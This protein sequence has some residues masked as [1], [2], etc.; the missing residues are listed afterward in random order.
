MRKNRI[1]GIKD[2]LGRWC[3]DPREV[4]STI[5]DFYSNLFSSSNTCQP[6]VVLDSIQC[7]VT[8]DMN[9]H[10]LTEFSVDEV[11][12]ALSQ[13]APLK[14]PGPD[15]M[16]PLFYQHY[17]DLVGKDI[18]QSVLAFLNSA[19]LP[20]HLNH[21]FITLIPKVKNPELV[22]EF[23]PI[24]LCNVLYKI[25]SKVLANQLKKILPEIITENQSAFT[26]NHLIMDNILLAFESLHSMQ[27]H[28]SPKGGYMA[29]KL[30]MSKAYDR[31]EW[32]FLEAI[33]RKLGFHERWISLMMLCIST[34]S[35]SILINGAPT[36]FIKPTRGIRQGDPLLPF[37]FL[38]CTEGLHGLLSQAA[39]RGDIHGF[40]LCRRS[41]S[42]THLLFA[43]DSLLFCRSN[44]EECQKV[45]E[46]LQVYEMG[47]GQQLNKAKTTIF[48]SKSTDEASR[49][50]IKEC[51]GVEEI[52]S[53]EK[54]LGLPSLVGRNKK[55]SFNY[56]KER[57]WRKLQGWEEKLLS[58]A[59]REILIKAVA[60]AIPTY[61][62]NCF[63]LPIGLC[64]EIEGLIRKFW[65]G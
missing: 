49:F 34:V 52:R 58:Q 7:I 11:H 29:L 3:S 28:N 33:M 4:A 1:D 62:M 61:S 46:V 17:W 38:L 26:K 48:F 65:W 42:L 2:A 59:G 27:N 37:L 6:D 60:Q 13:M 14:A 12:V 9:R 5:L 32:A 21:T 40:S 41:P 44:V 53:Y 19:Y 57:V 22:S 50:L 20:E 64:N 23:R 15:G 45:M 31:V 47:S 55:S 16:P 51:L 56:I 35:Y 30:D 10:L 18:T 43:D 25:F 36:G 24:S 63:K 39:V 8:N 54:Y